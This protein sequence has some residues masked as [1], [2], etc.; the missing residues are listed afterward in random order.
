MPGASYQKP[1]AERRTRHHPRVAWV[2]LPAEGRKGKPPSLPEGREWPAATQKAWERMWAKPQ[3]VMWDQDGSS[4]HAWVWLHADLMIGKGASKALCE[5]LRQ[6]EN[7]HGLNPKAMAQLH[8]RI[9]ADEV[10]ETRTTKRA[11]AA[12]KRPRL[13]VVDPAANA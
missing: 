6:I 5:E 3:A 8:W 13:R 10:T 2:D 9:V 11:A 12:P 7:L 1:D 4:L